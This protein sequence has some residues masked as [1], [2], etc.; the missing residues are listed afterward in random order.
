MEPAVQT[1]N[2]NGGSPR[3]FPEV[4]K[5]FLEVIPHF[6]HQDCGLLEARQRYEVPEIVESC[7]GNIRKYLKIPSDFAVWF[8]MGG[9]Y[10]NT[11]QIGY[12]MTS[13]EDAVI[14]VLETGHWARLI[15][16][17]LATSNKINTVNA[18]QEDP[19]YTTLEPS[20]QWKIDEEAELFFYVENDTSSGFNVKHPFDDY[21]PPGIVI[22]QCSTLLHGE[23][24]YS[25]IAYSFATVRKTCGLTST[26]TLNILSDE[27]KDKPK[28]SDLHILD[29]WTHD[30]DTMKGKAADI[31]PIVYTDLTIKHLMKTTSLADTEAQQKAKAA[32]YY[33]AV[34]NSDG[35]YCNPIDPKHRSFTAHLLQV[36]DKSP[37][38]KELFVKEAIERNIVMMCGYPHA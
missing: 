8:N 22:D 6:F 26:L 31:L 20:S 27:Y 13:S 33:E 32:R 28:R 11:H 19:L 36:G 5:E 38:M 1:W 37:E 2:F 3:I 21:M 15:G 30:I 23:F 34:D 17:R 14:N 9:C 35:F 12:N 18:T 7:L 29:D 24:D 25:E 16:K 10:Q 4:Q